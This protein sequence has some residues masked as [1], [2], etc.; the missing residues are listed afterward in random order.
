MDEYKDKFTS[1]EDEFQYYALKALRCEQLHDKEGYYI[2]LKRATDLL[3][4]L[5]KFDEEE[6]E[7]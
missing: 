2:Y 6:K 3:E 1:V 5:D 7:E 4:V